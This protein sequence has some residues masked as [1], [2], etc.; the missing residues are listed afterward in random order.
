MSTATSTGSAGL[1]EGIVAAFR[2]GRTAAALTAAR[3]AL[4]DRPGGHELQR[5]MAL[6]HHR[7]D[8]FAAEIGRAHV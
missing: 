4:A 2:E 5:L 1:V 7:A 3:R 6:G 8:D